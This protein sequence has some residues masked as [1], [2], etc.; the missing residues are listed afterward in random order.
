MKNFITIL[1]LTLLFGTNWLIASDYTKYVNPF[2]GTTYNGHVFPGPC[3]PLG[4]VQPSP[5]TGNGNWKY[6]GGYNRDDDKI[7]FFG[8]THIS[9]TGVADL[10]DAAF[11]PFTGS[12]YKNDFKSTFNKNSEIAEI[13]F[14]KVDLADAKATVE[15]SCTERTAIYEIT[16]NDDNGGLYFD[17]QSGLTSDR[18]DWKKTYDNRVLK[19]DIR[20][21]SQFEITGAQTVTRWVKR[22]VFFDIVFDKP[23][24]D[25]ILTKAQLPQRGDKFTLLFG[26]KKGETLKVKISLSTVS[27]ENAQMNLKAEM[28]H[29]DFDKVVAQNKLA[30]NKILNKIQAKGSDDQLANFYTCMYHAF[31]HPANIADTNGQYRGADNLV[32]TSPSGNYYSL[33]SLWD[34]YRAEHPLFTVIAPEYVNDF[35]NSMLAHYDAQGYMPIWTLWGKENHCMIGNHSIAVVAEAIAKGFKGFDYERALN[36][37]V[38]SADKKLPKSNG[39]ELERQGYY[40]YDYFKNESVS[41]T[42]EG[43]YDDYAIAKTAQKLGKKNIEQRFTKRSL[44]YRNLFDFDLLLMRAK[45]AKGDWREPFDPLE[46][47]HDATMGGDFTEG[48]AWQYTWHVQHDIDGLI[49]MF[50]GSEKFCERLNYFFKN[51][52]KPKSQR[53]GTTHDVSGMI[54]QYAHGN[55]PSHH[56]IYMFALAGQKWRTQELVREVFDK[57]YQP[58]IDGLC[59]NDD[60]GQMSAWAIFSAM[61]FYPVDPVST[62]YVLGAPQLPEMTVNLANG[63]TFKVLARNISKAN[64]Y[65]KSVKLNGKPYTKNCISHADIVNGGVL[66]FEMTNTPQK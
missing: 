3:M 51:T 8:Q 27:V 4:L 62:E 13:G 44:L 33:F 56:V 61:G 41:R 25:T 63:K 38:D 17:F 50:G 26:L 23:I 28:P 45:N 29:W 40:S 30:W 54:G 39:K 1:A 34:T 24:K 57:F 59:G 37:F 32:K 49:N 42:L 5:E 19:S 11:M 36:A 18:Y 9:G 20:Q 16:F 7:W 14:Y 58:T 6:T 47:S 60:C 22:D 2:I 66:E 12:P 52:D 15:I 65:V 53:K 35:A 48:N 64:K 10:G 46:L 21:L 43:C 55:E 31:I